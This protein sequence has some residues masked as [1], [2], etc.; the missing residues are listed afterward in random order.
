MT[1]DIA[2]DSPV[3]RIRTGKAGGASAFSYVGACQEALRYFMVELLCGSRRTPAAQALPQ[4]ER[5][6]TAGGLGVRG[7]SCFT[8]KLPRRFHS[9]IRAQ[10][11]MVPAQEIACDEIDAHSHSRAHPAVE[12]LAQ[13]LLRADD[14]DSLLRGPVVF[15]ALGGLDAASIRFSFTDGIPHPSQHL[16]GNSHGGSLLA[17]RASDLQPQSLQLCRGLSR[18]VALFHGRTSLW[19]PADSRSAGP[20]TAGAEGDRRR[21]GRTR[22]ELFHLEAS[23]KVSFSY[24]SSGNHGPG[25]RNRVRRDR[26]PFTF[27]G[28]SGR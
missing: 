23:S 28:S 20:S 22:L 17:R 25:P 7:W 24:S 9:A 5:R 15:P 6:V 1:R 3:R 26:R 27:T 13:K 2:A 4:P 18:G 21:I 11:I 8:S 14:P 10:A 16:A 12:A 19:Q